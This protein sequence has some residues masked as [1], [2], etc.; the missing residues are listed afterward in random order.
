[1]SGY[2]SIQQSSSS[3][4]LP[5]SSSTF[6]STR[7]SSSSP[8]FSRNHQNEIQMSNNKDPY[9]FEASRILSGMYGLVI[10]LVGIGIINAAVIIPLKTSS[11][12]VSSDSPTPHPGLNAIYS[13]SYLVFLSAIG[14]LFM[15]PTFAYDVY[16]YRIY[17]TSIIGNTSSNTLKAANRLF[18]V[19]AVI[20]TIMTLVTLLYIIPYNITYEGIT[21]VCFYFAQ[22]I[23]L[24]RYSQVCFRKCLIYKRFGIMHLL[25]TNIVFWCDIVVY[26]TKEDYYNPGIYPSFNSSAQDD[27]HLILSYLG[28]ARTYVGAFAAE[29]CLIA[30]CLL[31]SMWSNVGRTVI[32]RNTENISKHTYPIMKSLYG[33]IAGVLVLSVII[34]LLVCVF[35]KEFCGYYFEVSVVV[36]GVVSV[37][38]LIC[39]INT[40]TFEKREGEGGA[41]PEELTSSVIYDGVLLMFCLSFF[42]LQTMYTT[43]SFFIGY[44]TTHMQHGYLLFVAIWLYFL[45]PIFQTVLIIIWQT[46]SIDRSRRHRLNMNLLIFLS[47]SNFA[48][49]IGEHYEL[50]LVALFRTEAQLYGKYMWYIIHHITGPFLILYFF[51]S[52]VCLFEIWTLF[53]SMY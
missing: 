53:G 28:S 39:V 8:S 15:L 45:F 46:H 23:Y 5:C 19:A 38:S 3:S 21:C 35:V 6:A 18:G 26:D 30:V 40:N 44:K 29:Y 41:K 22:L 17:S 33:I 16:L 36:Y 27:E 10:T 14:L 47:I 31:R 20:Y 48:L 34:A 52:S 50:K 9:K 42:I 7:S 2:L 1:M 13:N 37:C 51:H 43:V 12:S 25:S 32:R 4:F 11:K 24:E 49:W